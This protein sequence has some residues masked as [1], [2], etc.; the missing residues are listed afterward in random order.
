MKGG[1]DDGYL[2]CQCF[3]GR[4]PG[5][6]IRVLADIISSFD[7]LEILDA[8]CGEGKNAVYFVGLGAKVRAIDISPHALWN[9][10]Q[11]WDSILAQ[12]CQWELADIQ[13]A[14]LPRSFYDVVIAYGL[15]HCLPNEKAIL[16]TVHRFQTCTKMHG[17]NIIVA[18]NSRRQDLRA[19][20]EL[21]PCLLEHCQYVEMYRGWELIRVSDED[22]E[23]THPHNN[24]R[25]IHSM[26]RLLA[27]K[28]E[29]VHP[30]SA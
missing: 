21:K 22:L 28:I 13:N 18:F 8:G 17:Y 12:R 11:A 29:H 3:W 25:H 23:E 19:H 5:R 4:Q 27:K 7:G 26:T 9:A 10:R 6:L 24:M 20:P 30:T 16:D 14:S 15:L 2:S 1:Y